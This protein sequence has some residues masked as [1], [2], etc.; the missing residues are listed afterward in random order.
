MEI[1]LIFAGRR[2]R[3]CSQN[4]EIIRSAVKAAGILICDLIVPEVGFIRPGAEPEK[5]FSE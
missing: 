1:I 4:C 5:L 3:R 2:L